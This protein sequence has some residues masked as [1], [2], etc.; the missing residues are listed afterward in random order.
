MTSDIHDVIVR[1]AHHD[2]TISD[3]ITSALPPGAG[4]TGSIR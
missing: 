2:V 1:F 4:S 3:T